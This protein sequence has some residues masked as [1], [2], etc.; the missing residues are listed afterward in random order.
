MRLARGLRLAKGL[1][2]RKKNF[3]VIFQSLPQEIETLISIIQ[4][5]DDILQCTDYK[6]SST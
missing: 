4:G 1:F 3:L 2:F 6:A 5:Q